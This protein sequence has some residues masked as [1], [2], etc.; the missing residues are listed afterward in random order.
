[1]NRRDELAHHRESVLSRVPVCSVGPGVQVA[2]SKDVMRSTS[3]RMLPR[4]K[5]IKNMR[6]SE[7]V[8]NR[9][10]SKHMRSGSLTK[11]LPSLGRLWVG[12]L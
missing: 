1:M 10:A 7:L 3:L 9:R 6:E 2:E 5:S 11:Q 12:Q 4:K 8:V